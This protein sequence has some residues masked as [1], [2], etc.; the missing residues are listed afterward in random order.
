MTDSRRNTERELIML[1]VK[2]EG[3]EAGQTRNLSAGGIYFE[4]AMDISEGATLHLTLELT[5]P[6]G[7]L[8]LHC[9]GEVVRLEKSS[10]RTG[11]AVKII[12]SR[13]EK[14]TPETT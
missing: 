4:S 10:G 13:L 9:T 6:E 11:V 8:L 3:R 12:E 5:G 1:R 7:P 14:A 2:V